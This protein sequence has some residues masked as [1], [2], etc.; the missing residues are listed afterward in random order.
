MHTAARAYSDL[1]GFESRT[2]RS[3]Y[4]VEMVKYHWQLILKFFSV[5]PSIG[6]MH[7]AVM[8]YV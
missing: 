2:D 6:Y 3:I 5:L 7:A 8:Q 1:L 4:A